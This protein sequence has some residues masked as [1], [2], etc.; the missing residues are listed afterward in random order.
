[1]K[2]CPYCAEKVQDKAI[3]CRYCWEDLNEKESIKTKECP[4]CAEKIEIKS[5][6]CEYCWEDLNEK[7]KNI[8]TKICPYC[9]EVIKYDAIKCEHCW[10][11]LSKEKE[12]ILVEKE[13][14]VK[15]INKSNSKL[16][17]NKS[18]YK[19]NS[20][21]YAAIWIIFIILWWG[22]IPTAWI[23]SL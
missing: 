15:Y 9:T 7:K 16:P 11:L 19:K 6:K 5:I 22:T 18:K 8:T 3:K 13:K 4:S 17:N 21:N 1:M 10:E 20:W 23:L 14:N 2:D 12:N